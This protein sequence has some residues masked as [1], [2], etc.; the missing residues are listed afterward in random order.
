MVKFK[1]GIL[2]MHWKLYF[3]I[4]HYSHAHLNWEVRE[5][6]ENKWEYGK[7]SYLIWFCLHNLT[8][9]DFVNID[10]TNIALSIFSN[11]FN[12]YSVL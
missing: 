7:I 12:L 4:L 5:A 6:I 10:F 2:Q 9:I 11:M 1:S 8:N 3:D